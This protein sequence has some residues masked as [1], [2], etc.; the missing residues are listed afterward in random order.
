MKKNTDSNS[1]ATVRIKTVCIG[2]LLEYEFYIPDY[3]RGYRWTATE[4]RELLNDLKEYQE[5]HTKD[6]PPYYLQPLVVKKR[7]EKSSKGEQKYEVIDGQQRLTTIGLILHYISQKD[8]VVKLMKILEEEFRKPSSESIPDAVK[9]AAKVVPSP[10]TVNITYETRDTEKETKNTEEGRLTYIIDKDDAESLDEYHIKTVYGAIQ[11]WFADLSKQEQNSEQEQNIL[12]TL[13]EHTEVIWYEPDGDAHELFQRLNIG[14]I[15]LTNAELI[16]ALFLTSKSTD[17]YGEREQVLIAEQ[18]NDIER[19]L[20]DDHFWY[21][22]TNEDPETYDTRIDLLFETITGMKRTDRYALYLKLE[23]IVDENRKEKTLYEIWNEKVIAPFQTLLRFYEDPE[24]YNNV[25]YIIAAKKFGDT[26]N[27]NLCSLWQKWAEPET[28]AKN[29]ISSYTKKRILKLIGIE[30]TEKL[31]HD[32][33]RGHLKSIK[34]DVNKL[35]AHNVLL[36]HNILCTGKGLSFNFCDYK[37]ERWSLE[38]IYPQNPPQEQESQN[39]FDI[40]KLGN[41]ALLSKEDNS[42]VSNAPFLDKKNIIIDKINQGNFVPLCTQRVFLRYYTQETQ[43][44][45]AAQLGKWTKETQ[46]SE[47]A[48]LNKWTKETQQSEASQL[49]KWTKD[50]FDAYEREIVN[51]LSDFFGVGDKTSSTNDEQ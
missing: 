48:Q 44:S 39:N 33:L 16:R 26:T 35:I 31:N 45:E 15:P 1:P 17:I 14:R 36:L 8:P 19:R 40:N 22:L 43:Q 5:T 6:S 42:S 27:L 34:F 47:A 38:H 51:T 2:E 28:S 49:K 3:Q 20:A 29:F 9:H 10:A 30:A 23:K 7:K 24:L 50:D 41:L 4:V 21:F 12:R 46:Q 25:G 18:W 37:K 32:K 13:T 11:K